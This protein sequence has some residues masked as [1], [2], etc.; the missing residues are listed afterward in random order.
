MQKVEDLKVTLGV[1]F[2]IQ[3]DHSMQV[4]E[5]KIKVHVFYLFASLYRK[6]M[7][8]VQFLNGPVE[9]AI[10]STRSIERF[11]TENPKL[12][13][14]LIFAENVTLLSRNIIKLTPLGSSTSKYK[15]SAFS[16]WLY[17]G[18]NQAVADTIK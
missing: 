8:C 1:L 12:V 6:Y 9:D 11:I 10:S 18:E 3:N 16:I 13:F 4:W 17:E 5:K 2:W 14:F 15:K 7:F